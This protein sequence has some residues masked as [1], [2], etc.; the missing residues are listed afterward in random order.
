MLSV[1]TMKLDTKEHFLHQKMP[2]RKAVKTTARRCGGCAFDFNKFE[3]MLNVSKTN[4]GKWFEMHVL[5]EEALSF[6]SHRSQKNIRGHCRLWWAL[7]WE[8]SSLW[9]SWHSSSSCI[10]FGASDIVQDLVRI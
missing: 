1:Y 2:V 4:A 5:Q 10:V 3:L 7:H 6:S 8:L 9:V